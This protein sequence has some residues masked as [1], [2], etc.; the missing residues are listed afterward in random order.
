MAIGVT[1]S[2]P[3]SIAKLLQDNV[4]EV[5]SH[6]RDYSWGEDEVRQLFD[7]IEFAIEK[8][9]PLYFVGL[10]V[11][12]K[13]DNAHLIV[14]DGQQ[15]LATVY[16]FLATVRN[17]LNSYTDLAPEAL[18]VQNAFLG[19]SEFGEIKVTP[20]LV[21]NSA[22]NPIFEQYV[23][24]GRPI[25]DLHTA[26]SA[27]KK[28][29]RSRRLLEAAIYCHSRISQIPQKQSE[30]HNTAKYLYKVMM[31]LRDQTPVVNVTVPSESAAFTIFETLNDRG[32]DLSPLDLIKNHL[33]LN[34]TAL[35]QAGARD[36]EQRWGQMMYNL[37]NVR[38]DQ[39]LKTFWTSRHGRVQ[40][41]ILFDEFKSLHK[42]GISCI[43]VS[44]DMLQAAEHYA[45]IFSSDD[46]V[47]S[48]Y[49]DKEVREHVRSLRILGATQTHPII[50]A[51]LLRFDEREMGRLLRLLEVVIVRYQLIGGGRTGVLE[52]ATANLAE[53]IWSRT[54]TTTS[55]A[56]AELRSVYPLDA[57][58]QAAFAEKM[59]PS[60]PKTQYLL[61][62]LE[63]EERRQ[64]LGGMAPEIDV[65]L[66]LT[67]EH[68]YP[69]NPGLGWEEIQAEDED[70][71]LSTH[72]GNT[73]LL[74][75]VNTSLGNSPFDTKRPVYATSE[76]LLTKAISARERWNRQAI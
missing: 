42:D 29:D 39:Y 65:G 49:P 59:E 60:G 34:V 72:L 25:K 21:L 3:T 7:D 41:N 38:P 37:E 55:A 54:V 22:N 31:F 67:V 66:N 73:C 9:V 18:K 45:A 75:R 61:R 36:L 48:R 2:P 28:S 58:F 30:Y 10:M 11:F 17:W 51:A 24:N 32:L 47:W 40:S 52:I 76:L 56:V 35:S 4:F 46:L 33:F 26:L 23:V 63:A 62:K 71:D 19:Q 20:R 57:E 16:I 43:E 8:G 69:L 12:M 1:E 53:K 70:G 74:S 13:A 68:V 50:L 14:L 44:I 5:P 15:R 64:Q 6:Q 27:M